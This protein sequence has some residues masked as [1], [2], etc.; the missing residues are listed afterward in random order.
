VRS[1]L[2]RVFTRLA[3]VLVCAAAGGCQRSS[4]I[5]ECIEPGLVEPDALVRAL[6]PD[7]DPETRAI[8]DGSFLVDALAGERCAALVLLIATSTTRID[9]DGPIAPPV[10]IDVRIASLR[11]VAGATPALGVVEVRTLGTIDSGG[12]LVLE[13]DPEALS[14]SESEM[15][16]AARFGSRSDGEG[17]VVRSVYLREE[18]A[19]FQQI[20]ELEDRTSG[21]GGDGDEVET[22]LESKP[23]TGPPFDLEVSETRRTCLEAETGD[24]EC[25][26][27]TTS[28]TY[29]WTGEEYLRQETKR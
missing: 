4:V 26:R 18:S 17:G 27:E 13:L 23:G 16:I 9:P 14:L 21:S 6:H 25:T 5:A 8:G 29:A 10:A 2:A 19:R 7:Y 12:D 15:A 22:S 28:L 20:L 1:A 11:P 3:V 24:P